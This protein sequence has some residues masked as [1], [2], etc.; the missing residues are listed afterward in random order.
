M[1]WKKKKEKNVSFY[2]NSLFFV[3]ATFQCWEPDVRM[4]RVVSTLMAEGLES[5]LPFY[6]GNDKAWISFNLLPLTQCKN[7]Q[8]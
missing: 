6:L 8:G 2:W 4:G 7:Y 1:D 3:M 5:G